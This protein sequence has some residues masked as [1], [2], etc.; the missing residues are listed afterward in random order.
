MKEK[1]RIST[2]LYPLPR[3]TLSLLKAKRVGGDD[4]GASPS[5]PQRRKGKVG[6][7]RGMS[8]GD[9]DPAEK[10]EAERGEKKK[11]IASRESSK[12]TWAPSLSIRGRGEEGG[13]GG[14]AA[15]RA[16]IGGKERKK[17][18]PDYG[19]LQ[20][21][22]GAFFSKKGEKK[23][24]KGAWR[25]GGKSRLCGG[26]TSIQEGNRLSRPGEREKKERIAE[27]GR[28]GR[29]RAE[30]RSSPKKKKGGPAS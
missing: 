5:H 13:G 29:V 4:L 23:K 26:L 9:R 22:D 19:P 27:W 30:F 1:E 25:R 15:L 14:K 2:S 10:K 12:T 11:G 17:R 6:F 8:S 21:R 18:P 28:C 7:L 20:V 16:R 24:G 3:K